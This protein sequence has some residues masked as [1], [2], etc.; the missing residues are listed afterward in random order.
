MRRILWLALLAPIGAAAQTTHTYCYQWTPRSIQCSTQAPGGRIDPSIPLSVRPPDVIDSYLRMQENRRADEMLRLEEERLALQQR[1]LEQH[2]A[3]LDAQ[4]DVLLQQLQSQR[5][6]TPPSE[7]VGAGERADEPLIRY[8]K[9]LEQIGAC[10]RLHPESKDADACI[11]RLILTDP[12]FARTRAEN[13]MQSMRDAAE[14]KGPFGL[15]LK[16]VLD[17]LKSAPQSQ[18]SQP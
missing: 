18:Q 15:P 14:G 9:Y 7:E 12:D 16:Q 2:N 13:A 11:D 10:V 3:L 1:L 4:T 17:V 8:Q 5:A 6:S